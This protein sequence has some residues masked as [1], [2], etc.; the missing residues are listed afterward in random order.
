MRL[1]AHL[2]LSGTALWA[3]AAYGQTP[4]AEEDGSPEISSTPAESVIEGN[5]G[6]APQVYTP[7]YFEK[8]NP[9]TAR[10]MVARLPGFTLQGGEGS[11]RGFGQ[12]SLNILINGRRPSSKSSDE[13][14]LD[15]SMSRIRI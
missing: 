6:T 1:F 15:S 13:P 4:L 2:L 14:G 7:D 9:N 5:S 12:A 10:D 3:G 8:F 11:E